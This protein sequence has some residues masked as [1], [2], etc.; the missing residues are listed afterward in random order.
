MKEIAMYLADLPEDEKKEGEED[1]S[2]E[3]S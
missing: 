1:G 3:E 2:E